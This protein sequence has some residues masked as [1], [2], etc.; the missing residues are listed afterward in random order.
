MQSENERKQKWLWRY[1]N[2]RRAEARIRKQILDEMDRATATTKALSPVVVSGG[3]GN[4]KIEEAVP[5]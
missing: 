1:Q 4:S 5:A 3:S 2:S